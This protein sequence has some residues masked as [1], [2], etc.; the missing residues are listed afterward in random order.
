VCQEE[1]FKQAKEL[2]DGIPDLGP[3]L[4]VPEARTI[5]LVSYLDFIFSCADTLCK[6]F[7]WDLCSLIS[8]IHEL[9][10]RI[11]YKMKLSPLPVKLSYFSAGEKDVSEEL[12]AVTAKLSLLSGEE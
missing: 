5:S 3:L 7:D 8:D 10:S 4:Q 9:R 12:E 6:I 1:D 11:L 2:L